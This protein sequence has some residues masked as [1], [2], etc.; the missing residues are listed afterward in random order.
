MTAAWLLGASEALQ[1]GSV[2]AW[3]VPVGGLAQLALVWMA[4]RR[5]GYSFKLRRPR[6]T[7]ELKRLAIIAAPAALAGGVVQINLLVGR[8]VASVYDGAV[9][10]LSYADRLYQL[11]L[12]VVGIAIGIVL[13][14]DLTRR[15]RAG[16]E[17]GGRDAFNRAAE[18]SLALT[19]PAAIAL[20]LVPV[21]LTAVL[22]ERG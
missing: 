15:L 19:I 22:F 18:I 9:A 13:L 21:P 2:L 12:G 20:I 14:P 10:W 7:P 6:M 5:A 17:A 16:D 1:F 4:T 8:Q 3:A 11:P